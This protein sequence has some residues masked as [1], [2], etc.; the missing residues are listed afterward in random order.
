MSKDYFNL[1]DVGE[2]L[3]E[4]E[5]IAWHVEVG[6]VVEINQM[7]VEI[8]TAKSV[9]ELPSPFAGQVLELCVGLGETVPVGT[10]LMA[11]GE[12]AEAVSSAESVDTKEPVE[13]PAAVEQPVATGAAVTTEQPVTKPKEPAVEKEDKPLVLVGSGTR[14]AAARTIRLTPPEPEVVGALALPL[15]DSQ[16]VEVARE[17]RE[18]IRGVRKAV[19]A[20]MTR[21][22]FTAPHA[23]EWL[24]ADVT[25]M[26]DLVRRLRQ[27][28]AWQGVR[29][30][31]LLLVVKAMLVAIRRYPE[32]NA[33]WDN[34]RQ[35]IVVKEYVNL[36][37]AAATDRGLLVPNIKDAHLLDLRGLAV[38]LDS[39]VETARSGRTP[40][41]DMARGT[42]TITNIGAFGVDG[43]TP[44]LNP[45]ESAI[46]AVGG[47]RKAP[48]V[49]DDA[50][51]IRKTA[52][53]SMSFDH[54]LVDGELGSRVLAAV[55][56]ILTDPV[57][58]LML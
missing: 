19:A 45:G 47:I 44:I 52:T 36:G 6:D 24:T 8:E 12:P 50:L 56:G 58:A 39:L 53:L 49:V 54:R 10:P 51:T 31:P 30:T 22:A 29:V 25:A 16:A 20:A 5:V 43:G 15:R 9:V 27:D 18:P 41:E 7:V 32:I 57:T 35:E 14:A 1:P 48:W 3:T 11:I 28:R 26:M 34:D 17:R 23:T 40:P 38:A 55:A 37:I 42:I 21:S 2:G 46:L 13:R 33:T 4:A